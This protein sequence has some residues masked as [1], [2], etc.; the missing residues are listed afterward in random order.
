MVL[1]SQAVLLTQGPSDERH[2]R[3]DYIA[4]AVPEVGA[5]LE[6]CLARGGQL[7]DATPEGPLAIP[8][9]WE[10]GVDYVFL[11]SPEGAKVEL[12]ARRPPAPRLAW[13]H[14]QIGIS[15]AEFAQMRDFFLDL[16]LTDRATVTLDR[17][18]GR[19]DV[20]FLAWGESVVEIYCLPE[21][22]ADPSLSGG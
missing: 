20:A 11:D 22:R 10:N 4:L 12:I 16:G 6:E 19:A 3:I 21:T 17:S 1:G 9:F 7:S 18:E 5:A 14:D 2:G 8:E 13:G 15:C